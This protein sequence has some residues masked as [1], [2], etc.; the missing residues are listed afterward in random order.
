MSRRDLYSAGRRLQYLFMT[1]ETW[2]YLW[3]SQTFRT[4]CVCEDATKSR[5]LTNRLS[6]LLL[7][8]TPRPC[9]WPSIYRATYCCHRAFLAHAAHHLSLDTSHCFYHCST[10][11]RPVKTNH[12][13]HSSWNLTYQQF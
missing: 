12:I 5:P 6:T 1:G 9:S 11:S 3:R 7:A 10:V 2:M 13:K 8:S 4:L